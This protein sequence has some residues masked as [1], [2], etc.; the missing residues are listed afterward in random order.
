MDTCKGDREFRCTLLMI[1]A[2]L[3]VIIISFLPT[4][5][6]RLKLRYVSRWLRRVSE[7]PS[8]WRELVWPYHL[9]GDEGCMNDALKYCG[10]YVKRFF[11]PTHVT[12][13][14]LPKIL[15]YCCSVVQLSLPATKLDPEKLGSIIQQL[16]EL[17]R[18]EVQWDTRF[19]DLLELIVVSINLKEV[20]IRVK[21]TK[22]SHYS[23]SHINCSI[24][25]CLRHWSSNGFTP[26]YVNFVT[27]YHPLFMR[28][29]WKN[30]NTLNHNLPD[31]CTGHIK[32][33]SKL[34]TSLNLSPVVPEFQ[35]DFGQSV[36]PPFVR[37]TRFGFVG[38]MNDSLQLTDSTYK[39]RV[40]HKVSLGE[41]NENPIVLNENQ[42]NYKIKNLEFVTDL[43]ISLSGILYSEHLEQI[44]IQCP[45][46]QRLNLKHNKDCLKTLD[47]LHAIATSCCNLQGL[48]IMNIS[49]EEV[50][51]HTRLW[52]ILGNMNLTQLGVEMCILLPAVRGN[53]QKVVS[54][55][56]KCTNLKALETNYFVCKSCLLDKSQV[57]LSYFLSLQHC[58]ISIN[59]R[60]RNTALQSILSCKEL[61]CLRYSDNI[62]VGQSLSV[63][64]SHNLQQIQIESA[65]SDIPDTFMST[66]SIHGRLVHVVLHVRSLTREGITTLVT[67]SPKL[68]TLHIVIHAKIYD[69]NHAILDPNVLE[70]HIRHM[71]PYRPLFTTGCCT[72]IQGYKQFVDEECSTDLLSLW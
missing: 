17:Q 51:N 42:L 46:L 26:N 40:V 1:P 61:K 3:L 38:L 50:E 70:N 9:S 44:A 8:L 49:V 24:D 65:F 18:L 29:L 28:V 19:K 71:F 55:F 64:H 2:E 27:R 30:W 58:V 60:C 6:D 62:D 32:V 34:K 35:L 41:L 4:P 52:Q 5:C 20:T 36:A 39:G 37:A 25:S 45:N 63:V 13:S 33:Y 59:H 54:L 69:R 22:L 10:Q 14:K 16:R 48:N 47:G 66:I 68:R 53:P 43:D 67:N 31:G 72:I 56:Q 12:P 21:V 11:F 57:D 15:E 23:A 7:T